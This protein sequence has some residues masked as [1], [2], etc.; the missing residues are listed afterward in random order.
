MSSSAEPLPSTEEP[1][2]GWDAFDERPAPEEMEFDSPAK[3]M[4]AVL[5]R[6]MSALREE[7]ARRRDAVEEVLAVAVDQA[8]LVAQL[9]DVLERHRGALADAGLDRVHREL[10]LVREQMLDALRGGGVTVEELRGRPLAEV[11]DRVEVLGWLHSDEYAAEVVA[12]VH[13]AVVRH[14]GTVVRLGRITVGAPP[15]DAGKHDESDE[16]EPQG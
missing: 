15:R 2:Y 10:R 14:R 4:R 1:P 7:R 11:S 9:E 13:D 6:Y 12:Q 5:R 3:E 8:V 16:E